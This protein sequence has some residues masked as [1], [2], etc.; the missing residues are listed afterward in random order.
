MNPAITVKELRKAY[1]YARRRGGAFGAL[2]GLFHPDV[3]E[4]EAVASVSFEIA[5]GERVAIIGPNGAGKSTTLKMLSGVLEPS[6]G[7]A[8]VLG[9]TPWKERKRLAYEI[10]VVFGQRSQLWTELPVRDSF[11]LLRRVY[12]QEAD[13]FRRRRD[14]LVE[15]FGVGA[16]LDQPVGR[17][18]LGQRMRC[19]IVASLLHGPRLLFL[20]EPTIGLDVTA[21]AQ[22]RDF[23]REQSLT[24]GQTVVL[25]SH[26]TR[27]I[28][29][30]C[31][32]VIVI[33]AGKIVLDQPTDQL[34]RRF[35]ARKLITLQSQ[36]PVLALDLP[37]VT[38][39]PSEPHTT[40]LEI[41]TR[42]TRIDAVIAAA[43]ALGGIE[44]VTVE[45]PP[46]EEVVHEIYAALDR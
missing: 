3:V 34:R 18:S 11:A 26:D 17:L 15:R 14:A 32:R 19:E 31:E 23:I 37:G 38:R 41:D 24:E 20:D 44:D 6:G 27:D 36:A 12:D 2:A 43:L 13:G 8:Q 40:I 35:I 29:L 42:E 7:D 1:R 22:V 5:A 39:R 16:L 10:G 45:D 4:L 25:T 30:V 21:K 28:E 46:M 9:Y 33:N